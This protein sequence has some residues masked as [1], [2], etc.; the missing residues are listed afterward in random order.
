VRLASP[1]PAGSS[2]ES[3]AEPPAATCARCGQGI[4]VAEIV[5][6]AAERRDGNFLCAECLAHHTPQDDDRL[7][8]D[9]AGLLRAILTELQRQHRR[10]ADSLSFFRLLAYLVQ[11]ATLFCGFLGL[12]STGPERAAYLQAAIFLQLL[13][14][15]LLLFER[16]S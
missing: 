6:G 11:A 13:V 1:P 5:S 7:P 4:P 10:R 8:S 9:T 3:Y 14:L 16:H 15:T 2:A 12:V